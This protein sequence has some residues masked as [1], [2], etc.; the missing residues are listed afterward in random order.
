MLAVTTESPT[1]EGLLPEGVTPVGGIVLDLV[2]A[3]GVRV[4][5]QLAASSLFAG[6]FDGGLPDAFRGNPG[7]IGIQ[8]GFTPQVLAALGGGLSEIAV[9]ITLFDG[10]TGPTD[11]DEN[12][13]TLLLNGLPIGNFS[14]AATVE[15]SAD[16]LTIIS[17]NLLGGFRNN[18]LDTGFFYSNDP[19][20]LAA[21]F[22]SLAGGAVHY[23][24]EDVDPFENFFDFTQGVDGDL[25]DVGLPPTPEAPTPPLP[26][27]PPPVAPEL[28]DGGQPVDPPLLL[29]PDTPELL[30]LVL[31]QP[32]SVALVGADYGANGY[33][34]LEPDAFTS[35]LTPQAVDAALADEIDDAF[36][37]SGFLDFVDPEM[38]VVDLGDE[39][40]ARLAYAAAKMS[41]THEAST[42]APLAPAG[43]QRAAIA[44]APSDTVEYLKPPV[45]NPVAQ[46]GFPSIVAPLQA[47]LVDNWRWFASAAAA[48][49]LGGAA[50]TGRHAWLPAARKLWLR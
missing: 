46:S 37:L 4:V 19:A 12:E 43:E 18:V 34:S 17:T 31:P 15:T 22:D 39:P 23:Q 35:A 10:D 50:W 6:F 36:L 49:L 3:N 11:F 47:L 40:P 8:S 1:V 24:L 27:P 48:L 44:T 28:V 29:P 33:L 42:G 25:I 32:A 26:P 16:G 30:L 2:G 41:P 7:T 45:G 5:S 9:R 21:F 14:D 13:N 38:L 20:F